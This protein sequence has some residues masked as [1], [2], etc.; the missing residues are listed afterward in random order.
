MRRVGRHSVVYGA[1]LMLQKAVSFVMLPVYTRF[2]TPADYGVMTLIGM[3]LD[4][5]AIMAGTKVA[6]GIFRYYHKAETEADRNAVVST[7]LWT[8]SLSYGVI[9]VLTCVGAELLSSLVFSSPQYAPL[10]Q[11]AGA[12]LALQSTQVVPLAYARLRE[13]SSLFVVSNVFKLALQL[14]LNIYFIVGRGMGVRGVFLANLVATAVIGAWL[15]IYVLRNV[16]FHFSRTATRQLLRYGVPLVG[17][18]IATFFVTFGDRYFLQRSGTVS[19]V[20]IYS[21]AYQFGFLLATVGY[22]PFEMVWEPMRFEIAK[23]GDRDELFA[24]GFLYMNVMLITSAVVLSLFVPDVL[25]VMTTPAF[26]SAASLVPLILIGYVFQGWAQIQD[27]GIL[28]SERTVYVTVANWVAALVALGA[29]ALL[30]PRYLGVGAAIATALAFAAR[31]ACIYF[32]SQKFW[33]VNYR[34]NPVLRLCAAAAAIG[35]AGAL[36]PN[37]SVAVSLLA[38]CAL[39]AT[40]VA[41]VLNGNVLSDEDRELVRRWLASPRL[42]LAALR[43]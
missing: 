23:R 28:M 42:A 24:R 34:W 1:G 27:T 40:Y 15:T 19:D 41:I 16:G 26:Y 32:F 33:P 17:T 29:Y 7:A 39:F 8:L 30:I 13:R 6:L 5:I 14:G 43:P 36:L 12:A 3:T 10:I 9:G 18:Q 37:S 38:R 22:I 20:G 4:V 31:H 25:R 35:V 2:L 11:L 21:L